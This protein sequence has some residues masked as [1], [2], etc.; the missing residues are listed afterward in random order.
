MPLP[1]GPLAFAARLTSTEETPAPASTPGASRTDSQPHQQAMLQSPVLTRQLTSQNDAQADA[2]SSDGGSASSGQEKM[3]ERFVKLETPFPQT[4]AAANQSSAAPPSPASSSSDLSVAARMDQVQ[5]APPA[6]S[7]SNH[8]ITIRIPGAA[9]DQDTA[10]RFVERAGEV[11]VSVRTSD[12]EMAQTLRGGLSSLVTGSKTAAFA[13]RSG[14]PARTP[15]PLRTI[16]STLSP[17]PTARMAASIH[18]IRTLNRNP[19]AR[20]NPDG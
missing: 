1:P 4:Q 10:V 13:P 15:H 9:S 6:P 14:S 5:E 16:L 7:T 12:S 8:D 11:H 19:I 3:G 20:T 2:H 17:T 18:P